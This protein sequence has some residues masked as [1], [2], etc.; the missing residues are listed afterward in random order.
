MDL[1]NDFDEKNYLDANPDVKEAVIQGN[2][3]SGRDH[4]LKHGKNENRLL[5]PEL[6]RSEKIFFLLKKDGQ[7]LEIGP[8]HNPI[9]P[10]KQGFNVHIL[11]HLTAEGLRKK[12]L[13]H[14]KFGV[15]IENIEEVDFVWNGE[16]YEELIGREK[17]YDWIL[18]SHVIEHIP[19]LISHFHQ[20]EK[21]LKKN[22][23]LSLVIPDKRYCFDYYSPLTTA[24]NVID[25][26]FSKRVKPS[27]GQIFDHFSNAVKNS[28]NIAWDK[29]SDKH[30][31]KLLHNISDANNLLQESIKGHSYIDTHCWKFTPDSF[32][33]LISD[34]N[35]IGLINLEIKK[36]FDTTGCEFSVTLGISNSLNST[37]IDRVERLEKIKNT[38]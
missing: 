26:Y 24:G 4:Y 8:S 14:Q 16:P 1:L 19:D 7:G 33:L 38:A 2:F 17:F 35:Q 11:D 25:A 10:K 22:G 27:P 29:A 5:A 6:T 36:I 9:A 31:K 3:S 21:L 28:E 20:C 15:N 30:E 12:Y 23:Y 13:E 18:S 37:P 34:L 32:A